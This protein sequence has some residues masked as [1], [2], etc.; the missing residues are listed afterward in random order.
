MK[1]PSSHGLGQA[2]DLSGGIDLDVARFVGDQLDQKMRDYWQEIQRRDAERIHQ[3]V[4]ALRDITRVQE[5]YLATLDELVEV[6]CRTQESVKELVDR[7]ITDVRVAETRAAH[8]EELYR[9]AIAG[10]RT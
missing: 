3:Q 5:R 10:V 6:M 1:G 2:V 7:Y 9:H 4:I 8:Y